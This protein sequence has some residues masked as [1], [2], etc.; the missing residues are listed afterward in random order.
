[1]AKPNLNQLTVS[2]YD[3]HWGPFG[4]YTDWVT[5]S[6]YISEKSLTKEEFNSIVEAHHAPAGEIKYKKFKMTY[7]DGSV[8]FRH[9]LEEVMY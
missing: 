2:S 6:E 3:R 4:K 8:Y 7:G 9:V 1:M 5:E